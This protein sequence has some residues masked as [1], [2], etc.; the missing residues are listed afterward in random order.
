[1]LLLVPTELEAGMIPAPLITTPLAIC[2]FGLAEAGARAAHAI[3]TRPE[4]ADG[5]ILLGAAG[6]YD[7]A[8]YPV[9]SAVV[10]GQRSLPWHRRR[11]PLAG[12]ARDSAR[13]ELLA[14]AGSGPEIVS[15]AAGL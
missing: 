9:G 2:G 11:R 14:L 15:V 1:M 13:P 12:G 8:A 7:P 4:A 10:A 3:A 5:V 6:T